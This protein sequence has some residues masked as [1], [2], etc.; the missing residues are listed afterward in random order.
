MSQTLTHLDFVSDCNIKL[1]WWSLEYKYYS[2]SHMEKSNVG[3]SLHFFAIRFFIC[4]VRKGKYKS[5]VRFMLSLVG[6]KVLLIV[7]ICIVKVGYLQ[8]P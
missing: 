8:V 2:G 1:E 3:T 6:S 7:G 5:L 4:D